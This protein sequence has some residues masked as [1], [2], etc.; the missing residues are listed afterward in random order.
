MHKK[1]NHDTK[2]IITHTLHSF[3]QTVNLKK[4]R[5]EN[6]HIP[7]KRKVER[8]EVICLINGSFIILIISILS[9]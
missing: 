3:N 9:T 6:N 7:L 1:K 5:K 8:L 4:R 2:H